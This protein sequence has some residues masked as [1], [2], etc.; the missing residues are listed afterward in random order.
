MPQAHVAGQKRGAV[1]DAD[2]DRVRQRAERFRRDAVRKLEERR[3]NGRAPRDI[4]RGSRSGQVA[5]GPLDRFARGAGRAHARRRRGRIRFCLRRQLGAQRLERIGGLAQVDFLSG[6]GS[7][8]LPDAVREIERGA[9]LLFADP[10][11]AAHLG[12]RQIEPVALPFP[13]DRRAG[14]RAPPGESADDRS[15]ESRSGRQL[16]TQRPVQPVDDRASVLAVVI[17]G[18]CDQAADERRGPRRVDRLRA[19]HAH[20]DRKRPLEL[21]ERGESPVAIERIEPGRA[22]RGVGVQRRIGDPDALEREHQH[23]ASRKRA[24]RLVHAGQRR[25]GRGAEDTL[26]EPVLI[27]PVGAHLQVAAENRLRQPR[28]VGRTIRVVFAGADVERVRPQRPRAKRRP[29]AGI[30]LHAGQQHREIRERTRERKR[31]NVP[32]VVRVGG[33]VDERLES[34]GAHARIV[35]PQAERERLSGSI[36]IGDR[37][38]HV[39]DAAFPHLEQLANEAVGPIDPIADDRLPQRNG[40]RPAGRNHETAANTKRRRERREC[41]RAALVQTREHGRMLDEEAERLIVQR[42]ETVTEERSLPVAQDS[43]EH[44]RGGQRPTEDGLG[45]HR[46]RERQ[47]DLLARRGV[48]RS[49]GDCFDA[50]ETRIAAGI[51]ARRNVVDQ[52][53]ELADEARAIGNRVD[54]ERFG[55]GRRPAGDEDIL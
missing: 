3:A 44:G 8:D 43:R 25:L 28:R 1:V 19:D 22:P 41:R 34:L 48:A 39:R 51:S 37:V 14:R 27:Q 17:R 11:Q 53:R 47:R 42:G 54:P 16:G 15:L 29:A 18:A 21:G 7:G 4:S 13:L 20:H 2:V 50:I 46:R 23:A 55:D 6:H 26:P 40:V 31:P 10:A 12:G 38:V 5:P 36:D 24:Q 33:R 49:C 30:G 45:P 9:A 52:T 35:D 32:V